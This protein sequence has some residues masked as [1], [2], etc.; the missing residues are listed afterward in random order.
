VAPLQVLAEALQVRFRFEVA[1]SQFGD[2]IATAK[3]MF[4]LSRHLGEHPSEVADLVGLGAAHL[5]LDSIEE[6]VQQPGCP[7]LYWALTELPCPLVDLRKG[8][9][10]DRL[11]VAAMLR[12]IRD[13]A[14]MADA[15][16]EGLVG[17]LSGIMSLARERAGLPPRSFRARVHARVKDHAPASRRRLVESGLAPK[18]VDQLPPTQAILLD[19][20][21]SYEIRRDD[22]IKLIALPL[23][24]LDAT[25]GD[26]PAG[27]ED[28]LLTDLLPHVAKLRR[29]QAQLE[30]QIA[31]LRHV[32]ALRL[33]AADH[34]GKLPAGLADIRVPLPV[35]PITGKA[36][37]YAVDGAT[38]HLRGA[39]AGGQSHGA[40]VH[41]EV[42]LLK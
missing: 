9:Q 34:G 12:P 32:E 3:T 8:M 1:R 37:A 36:F 7:N 26:E 4:A 25:A 24:E 6:M 14:P 11:R 22:R 21:R 28:G 17:R 39:P 40:G 27:G 35:D 20:K 18:L 13:D 2:A 19:E 42:T 33:H 15:E 29:T 38:A 31:M 16:I 41:Y 10:G 30:Q 5:T 23:W